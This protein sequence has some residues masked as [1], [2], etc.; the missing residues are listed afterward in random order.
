MTVFMAPT[1]SEAAGVQL[2]G[3]LKIPQ[4]N[5]S[6][7]ANDIRTGECVEVKLEL[8]SYAIIIPLQLR[9]CL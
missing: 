7:D 5:L 3:V 2:T 6:S 1:L 4:V 9:Q 8:S